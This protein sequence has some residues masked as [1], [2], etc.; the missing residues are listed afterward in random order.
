M[1]N[2]IEPLFANSNIST[3]LDPN[4]PATVDELTIKT[5]YRD[6]GAVSEIT[7]G[8]NYGTMRGF[9][10][11]NVI[12]AS[13]QLPV[14]ISQDDMANPKKQ[15]LVPA[16][17]NNTSKPSNQLPVVASQDNTIKSEKQLAISAANVLATKFDNRQISFHPTDFV[18]VSDLPNPVE[19]LVIDPYN[20][21]HFQLYV[22]NKLCYD[23]API[24]TAKVL[25]TEVRV[26]Y[27]ID[28]WTLMEQ[29]SVKWE[30]RPYD[31]ESVPGKPLGNLREL[32]NLPFDPPQ[33]D[34][35]RTIT[36]SCPLEETERKVTC[37]LCS[38]KGKLQC[39]SCYGQGYVIAR[40]SGNT[41]CSR[42]HGAGKLD[43]KKCK[44]SGSL[45]TWAVLTCKWDTIHS[46]SCCQ[47]TFLPEDMILKRLKKK[48]FFDDDREW[49]GSLFL[50]N[51]G[52]L[53]ERISACIPPDLAKKFGQDIQKQ[54]Q[55][56]LA[57]LRES[58]LIPRLKCLIRQVDIIETDYQLEGY[59]NK[60]DRHNGEY[61]AITLKEKK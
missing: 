43:C 45:I 39:T 30:E 37:N 52:T 12:G 4:K 31:G 33:T 44:G 18:S 61:P 42:C 24:A 2:R 9:S 51:Y 8:T 15:L 57:R 20:F 35:E 5:N 1:S 56:H 48:T 28:I 23:S 25:K 55:T 49:N 26:A 41:Q 17:E 38:G 50:T 36:Q 19:T 16:L 59:V 40:N 3:G 14:S 60:S 22:K 27:R 54:Y 10:D 11:E 13:N 7:I 46:K 34:I 47:N 6:T 32:K 58:M 29:R 53:Y 21:S